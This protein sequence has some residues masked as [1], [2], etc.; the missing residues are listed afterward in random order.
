MILVCYRCGGDH[1]KKNCKAEIPA[2]T[3]VP[4]QAPPA[5]PSP[6]NGW[7]K[8]EGLDYNPPERIAKDVHA[9]AERIRQTLGVRSTCGNHADVF[10][11]EFRR[12]AGY[13]PVHLCQLR[14]M[15]AEQVAQARAEQATAL[16]TGPEANPE[17][18]IEERT[19]A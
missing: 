1:M 7:K 11:S 15:A 3:A 13:Q 6:A 9:I 2:V 18:S 12:T 4:A 5:S 10:T 16:I 8:T 14:E 19:A 17:I